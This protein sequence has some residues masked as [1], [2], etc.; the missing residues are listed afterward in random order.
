MPFSTEWSD[1]IY[2]YI[3]RISNDFDLETKR[4]DSVKGHIIIEDIWRLINESRIIVAD[5]SEN[6]PNVFYELGIAHTLGKDII[7]IAQNL[8]NIPFDIS[9]Y[10]HIIYSNGPEAF[11]ILDK[12]LS[13][14][15]RNIY[16]KSPSGNPIIDDTIK[17]MHFWESQEYDYDHLLKSS[18]LNL[19]KRYIDTDLLSDDLLAFCLMSSIYYGIVGEMAY[20]LKLN[21]NNL[22]A[23]KIL[24][25]YIIMTYRRPRYRSAL[26]LQYMA[27][28]VKNVAIT[29]IES[30]TPDHKLIRPIIQKQLLKYINDNLKSDPDLMGLGSDLKKF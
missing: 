6:N 11:K 9:L 1:A 13:E 26:L 12:E 4:A 30:E 20:W 14:H 3:K 8:D 2:S 22:Q 17:K 16:E 19:I 5:V 27:D 29:E 10:R 7:L 25:K 23:G 15:I 24:G 18:K 28:D 21:E